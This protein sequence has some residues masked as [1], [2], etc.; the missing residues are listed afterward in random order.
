[1]TGQQQAA[2]LLDT[3]SAIL[4]A[5]VASDSTAEHY[6]AQ[7]HNRAMFIAPVMSSIGLSTAIG[8][9]SNPGGSRHARRFIFGASV[10]TGFAGLVFHLTNIAGRPGGWNSTSLF[11]GAPLAAPL[12]IT[13]AGALGLAASHV[14]TG[15]PDRSTS[16]VLGW[17]AAA[18]LV[19]TSAEATALHFRGAFHNPLMYAPVVLPPLAATALAAA[20]F[21]VGGF[22]IPRALLRATSLLGLG[23]TLLHAWGI[24]RRM[25]GWRNWSQNVLAGPPLPAPP[26]FTG[27]ALAGLAALDL[28]KAAR[29]HG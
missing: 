22:G 24:H 26:A 4:M 25:G 29:H 21:G 27:L 8:A 12:G 17:L 14:A 7:F 6:R 28:M 23:G 3:A 10:L 11:Y 5:G 2:R 9:A 20:S 16:R 15:T 19:G 13:M 18:G 1:M